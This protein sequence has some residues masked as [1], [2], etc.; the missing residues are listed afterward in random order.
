ML[1]ENL[2]PVAAAGGEILTTLLE[3]R[4]LAHVGSGL[5]HWFDFDPERVI[6][7]EVDGEH[8]FLNRVPSGVSA[9][10]HADH[11][12]LV[13][14]TDD[15]PRGGQIRQVGRFDADTII[16]DPSYLVGATASI[17]EVMVFRLDVHASAST[18]I[19]LS[20]GASTNPTANHYLLTGSNSIRGRIGA[21]NAAGP[22]LRFAYGTWHFV[23]WN[24]DNSTKTSTMSIDGGTAQ[25]IGYTATQVDTGAY[26]GGHPTAPVYTGDLGPRLRYS[27]STP[28]LGNLFHA[29]NADKLA[30]VIAWG[31]A[32]CGQAYP[33]TEYGDIAPTTVPPSPVLDPD[34]AAFMSYANTIASTTQSPAAGV[35]LSDY[36]KWLKTVNLW[37]RMRVLHLPCLWDPDVALLNLVDPTYAAMTAVGGP[38]HTPGV[39]Y[40]GDATDA[41]LRSSVDFS[42]IP[43]L[44]VLAGNLGGHWVSGTNSNALHFAA[45]DGVARVG[46]RPASVA[47]GN[48]SA[49]WNSLTAVDDTQTTATVPGFKIV[50]RAQETNPLKIFVDGVQTQAL[51]SHSTIALP[52]APLCALGNPVSGQYSDHVMSLI[53]AGLPMDSSLASLWEAEHDAFLAAYAA[54][55]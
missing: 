3:D 10:V 32:V 54:A 55:L 19:Y 13:L 46:I 2:T 44:A 47:N 17:T 1:F 29:S 20:R 15:L 22:A 23:I 26:I 25:T 49:W 24:H 16:T 48:T 8:E 38:V 11:A 14:T 34:Y 42:T 31:K 53:F 37:T 33:E 4:I 12:N 43:G 18:K 50:N 40:G 41:L 28:Q 39:G 45:D 21:D 27:G 51:S 52:V 7:D 6:L 36:F 35:I 5:S 30:D 9:F